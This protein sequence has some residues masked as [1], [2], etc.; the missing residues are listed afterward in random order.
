MLARWARRFGLIAEDGRY[1]GGAARGYRVPPGAA[2]QPGEWAEPF[3]PDE[4][5]SYGSLDTTTALVNSATFPTPVLTITGGMDR[6]PHALAALPAPAIQLGAEVVRV[7][8][9]AE[10]VE[11]NWRETATGEIHTER[12]EALI[13]TLPFIVGAA[14]C[15]AMSRSVCMTSCAR[16]ATVN[17]GRH[18]T[19]CCIRPCMTIR[20]S[21]PVVRSSWPTRCCKVLGTCIPS[22]I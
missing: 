11:V 5:W 22:P 4:V 2:S 8:Q 13:C 15:C 19:W 16:P 12:A 10:G 3:P 14:R 21:R 1:R 9:D 6:L 17:R 18:S 7:R 20:A